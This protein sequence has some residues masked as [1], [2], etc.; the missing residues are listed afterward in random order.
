MAWSVYSFFGHVV[1]QGLAGLGDSCCLNTV[2]RK[3]NREMRKAMLGGL[4]QF[5]PHLD[6]WVEFT[7]L[8]RLPLEGNDI[9]VRDIQLGLRA[10]LGLPCGC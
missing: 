5:L 9:F 7:H 1:S 10:A 3:V 2:R 6:I 4:G 8:Y